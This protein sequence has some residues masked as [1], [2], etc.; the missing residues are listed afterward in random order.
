MLAPGWNDFDVTQFY[1]MLNALVKQGQADGTILILDTLRRFVDTLSHDGVKDFGMFT[2]KFNSAGG[3]II[4]LAHTNKNKT[5]EGKR[6]L[7]GVQGIANDA[8]AVYI[9]DVS[10]IERGNK[11]EQTV[12]F[13]ALP[14]VGGKVRGDNDRVVSYFFSR[15]TGDDY[16]TTLETVTKADEE[17]VEQQKEHAK[18]L[19]SLQKNGLVFPVIESIIQSGLRQMTQVIN[20]AMS[21]LDMPKHAVREVIST[22]TQQHPWQTYDNGYRWHARDRDPSKPAAKLL[23][24]LIAEKKGGGV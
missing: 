13:E 8:D 20:V 9:G 15:S 7:E 22:H 4:A 24:L 17:E 19:E 16:E 10:T 5:M 1:S 23:T 3:T 12:T 14:D 21:E 6:V 18:V 2:R 11:V